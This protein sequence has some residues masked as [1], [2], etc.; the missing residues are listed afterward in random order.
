[1]ALGQR[2]KA[3]VTLINSEIGNRKERNWEMEWKKR[4]GMS[5]KEGLG[6]VVGWLVQGVVT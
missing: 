4:V 2:R 5:F 3:V 1:M 6:N